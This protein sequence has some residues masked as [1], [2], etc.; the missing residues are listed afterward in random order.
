M[1][2]KIKVLPR[3]HCDAYEAARE[4]L[5]T[6]RAPPAR[7]EGEILSPSPFLPRFLPY[8][9]ARR[10]GSLLNFQ[11]L[12]PAGRSQ[13]VKHSGPGETVAPARNAAVVQ[14]RKRRRR[15]KIFQSNPTGAPR[16]SKK[17]QEAGYASG[18]S[19]LKFKF[20]TFP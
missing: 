10:E 2:G 3:F 17:E 9:R 5:S 11:I 7:K 18:G 20:T 13:L 1:K 6:L 4:C 15:R 14:G 8:Q 12:R 19:A 16:S